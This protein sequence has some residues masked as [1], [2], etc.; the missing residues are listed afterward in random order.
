M[1]RDNDLEIRRRSA[2]MA[3]PESSL[4]VKREDL[5]D[6]LTELQELRRHIA[7]SD[8]PDEAA[9]RRHPSGS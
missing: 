6:D 1:S 4:S 5:L 8:R 9:V 7:G 3:P 2:I